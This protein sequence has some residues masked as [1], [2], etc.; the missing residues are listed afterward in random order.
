MDCDSYYHEAY[1]CEPPRFSPSL[2]IYHKE[3]FRTLVRYGL[4]LDGF[5]KVM[6][7]RAA[8]IDA[9]HLHALDIDGPDEAEE[10]DLLLSVSRES[11][12]E[13]HLLCSFDSLDLARAVLAASRVGV[14]GFRSKE[15][16]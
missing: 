1:L 2:C 13:A 11:G 12:V 7:R 5:L 4:S 3:E 10:L 15:L 16:V 9:K 14:L 6:L 8:G